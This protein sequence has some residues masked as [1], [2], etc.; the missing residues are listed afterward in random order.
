MRTFT[1]KART[2]Q[3]T[4]SDESSLLSRAHRGQVGEVN[5]ILDRQHTVSH[6]TTDRRSQDNTE[7]FEGKVTGGYSLHFRRDFSRIPVTLSKAVAIQ[8]KLTINQPG[9]EYEREADHVAAQVMRTTAPQVERGY[10]GGENGPEG[11]AD[12]PPQRHRR[13]QTKH[14]ADTPAVGDAPSSVVE[15]MRSPGQPLDPA[16]RAFMEPRFGRDFSGI[17][18][19]SD[20]AAGQSAQDINARAYTI[21]Q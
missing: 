6:Q 15:A 8:A 10:D 1:Q 9:D 11:Y 3:Q 2:N 14:V 5:S 20:S 13:L 16:T 7:G 21:G 18:V 17:R 19:H 4:A 12:K